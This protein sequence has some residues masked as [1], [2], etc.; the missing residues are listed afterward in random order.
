MAANAEV[1]EVSVDNVPSQKAWAESLGGIDFPLLADFH[2]KAAVAKAYGIYNEDRG[3]A[4]RSVFLI[5]ESGVIRHS[6]S[7]PQ[8]MIPNAT[9]V[10]KK[11]ATI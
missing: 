10:L 1:I 4:M 11:L 6:E 9:E 8:G 7:F 2:P 5:D 3:V